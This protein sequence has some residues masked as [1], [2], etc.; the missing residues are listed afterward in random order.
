MYTIE[1]IINSCD[2][3]CKQPFVAGDFEIHAMGTLIEGPSEKV[4]EVIQKCHEKMISQS[5]RV[6]TQIRID[7]RKGPSGTIKSKVRSVEEHLGKELP[8]GSD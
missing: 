2:K 4:F 3:N 1:K 6:V 5:D 8:K 7:D